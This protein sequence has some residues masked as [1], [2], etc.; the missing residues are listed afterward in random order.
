MVDTF[1]QY[2][3]TSTVIV[4]SNIPKLA[5]GLTAAGLGLALTTA[6]F[7]VYNSGGSLSSIG[8]N[9]LMIGT[10]ILTAAAAAVDAFHDLI[11]TTGQATVARSVGPVVVLIH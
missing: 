6:A 1:T 9:S 10:G 8:K 5:T 11:N 4:P 3:K 7:D 2:T